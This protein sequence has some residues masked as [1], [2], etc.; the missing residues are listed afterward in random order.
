MKHET[1]LALYAYW[2]SCHR[3]TGVPPLGIQA[4]ELAP[5]LPSL[6]LVE[7]D[8]AA[9]LQFRFCGATM[10][11]RYGRDLTDSSF[12]ELWNPEDRET[13]LQSVRLMASRTTGLVAGVMGES[14]AGG[15]TSFEMLLLPLAGEAR[16]A[17]AIGSMVR[18][19]GH[20]EVNR[21]RAKLSSQRLR[22]V[23]FLPAEKKRT[24]DRYLP[25]MQ[26]AM[27]SQVRRRYGHL[28]VVSGG[29]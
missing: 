10:A 11:T 1:S 28:T 14:V 3:E 2:Q 18:I 21:I 23:R 24:R 5:I 20:E 19:G 15:F 6:F 29:K 13:L 8:L 12:L 17:G 4:T 27:V 7:L 9:G 26:P 25:D 22:S 16:A